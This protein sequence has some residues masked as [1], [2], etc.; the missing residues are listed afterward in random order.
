MALDFSRKFRVLADVI[1]FV[2]SGKTTLEELKDTLSSRAGLRKTEVESIAR[3]AKELG[4]IHEDNERRLHPTTAGLAFE[5][6]M[7][8]V[9]FH[10]A[11]SITGMQA[12][13]AAEFKIC[14]TV[15]PIWLKKLRT[16]FGGI[17][18]HTLAGQKLVAENAETKLIIVTPY[19]DVGIMQVALKD[20]YA[21][22]VE[23]IIITSEPSLAKTFPRGV[24][25][26]IKKLETLIR[27][28]FKSG[29]VLF[30]SEDTTL[31]HAK[32]WC[33]DRSLLV[34]SANVKPD[35]TTDNLEIGIYTDNSVLVSAMWNL[36]E[37]IP[38]MEGVTCLLRIPP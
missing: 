9:D 3:L 7:A 27:G 25:F 1:R 4:F 14:I 21:K 37:Q 29:R 13:K 8:A 32:V 31:I 28:R 38:A 12:D 30:V 20:V 11:S 34:T 24:N 18:T 10:A 2:K 35:S 19:L 5:R 26:K 17:I 36:L 23:L 15:P 22:N 6:Y 16:V 33:S